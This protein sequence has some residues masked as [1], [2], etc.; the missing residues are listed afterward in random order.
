MRGEEPRSTIDGEVADDA[1]DNAERAGGI[2]TQTVRHGGVKTE[3][4]AE[5]DIDGGA[6]GVRDGAVDGKEGVADG[7]DNGAIGGEADDGAGGGDRFGLDLAEEV[8]LILHAG[9]LG[10]EEADEVGVAVEGGHGAMAET[11]RGLEGGLDQAARH[12]EDFERGFLG[13]GGESA[14]AD[15]ADLAA[16]AGDG[17]SGEIDGVV[18]HT[19]CGR[20]HFVEDGSVL[21]EA[22][23]LREALA[24]DDHVGEGAGHGEAAVVDG[25]VED[26]GKDV[27][28]TG[29]SGDHAGLRVAGHDEVRDFGE[30]F[31][32]LFED[33]EAF[34]GVAGAGEGDPEIALAGDDVF[35]QVGQ[36]IGAGDRGGFAA[37]ALA[38][39]E[40]ERVAD[41]VG[42]A[43]ADEHDDGTHGKR[44]GDAGLIEKELELTLI[45][46]EDAEG[47]APGRGLLGDLTRGKEE[48]AG[49]LFRS[50]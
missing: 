11:K 46:L 10:G 48:T 35:G 6:I 31:D 7:R 41:V 30:V 27:G 15:H 2:G 1:A 20:D 39:K 44:A 13:D 12:F 9:P 4:L 8:D 47:G 34:G 14:G 26:G 23:G 18:E 32:G 37:P 43:G 24:E 42:G 21:V 28:V 49:L 5:D 36:E 16:A 29:R 25:V 45:A 33:A 17:G 22:P 40:G 38:Q 19:G 50:R 3:E